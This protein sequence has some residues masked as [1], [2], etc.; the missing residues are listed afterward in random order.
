MILRLH[1]HRDIWQKWELKARAQGPGLL[2]G[3]GSKTCRLQGPRARAL[4][5][6]FC[7]A[8]RGSPRFPRQPQ[9]LPLP[10]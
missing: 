6:G 7:I 9:K 3:A 8:G 2:L 4:G 10:V 5:T 1:H